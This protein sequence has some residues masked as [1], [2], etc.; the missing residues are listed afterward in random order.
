MIPTRL[1]I[2]NFLPYR[3]PDP[4]RFDGVHLACL[5]GPNGAGKSSLLDAITWALWGRAR[6]ARDDE[7]IHLGQEDMLV[8]LDFDQEGTHYRV[9]RRRTAGKRG[10]SQLDLF[11]LQDQPMLIS[12]PSIKQTQ[13][14]INEILR[15]DYDTFT[16]SAFL[17]QGKADS[18]TNL[19]PAKRKQ[20]LTDILG[21]DQ[22]AVYEEKVKERLKDI[23]N[24]L[25]F[26]EGRIME[27][28]RELSR[29]PQ[30]E[31]DLDAATVNHQ[32]AEAARQVAEDR[33]KE[34]EH[35]PGD[36][37][38][39]Q[40]RRVAEAAR[41]QEHQR[42]VEE[43][44]ARMERL[45]TQIADYQQ[46]VDSREEIEAGYAALQSARAA[47]R[48]LSDKLM[49]LATL[50]DERARLQNQI[51]TAR[52]RLEGE[53]H[54]LAQRIRELDAILATDYAAEL[55]NIQTQV[56]ELQALDAEHD[57]LSEQISAWKVERERLRTQHDTLVP[58]G[59][60]LRERL[61]M[62]QA[63]D[64][65]LCPT[66]GQ[67][68]S[69]ELK[70]KVITDITA[71]M[72]DKREQVISARDT[73]KSLDDDIKASEKQIKKWVLELKRLNPLMTHLGTLQIQADAAAEAAAQITAY[74]QQLQQLEADLD[75]EN[76]AH[77]VREALAQLDE[78]QTAIGYDEAE[79]RENRE[80]ITAHEQYDKLNTRLSIALESLPAVEAS[81]ADSALRVE[82]L[83]QA[84]AQTDEGL[85]ALD[86]EIERLKV[87][88]AE[89]QQRDTDVRAARTTERNAYERLVNVQ[90]EL[91]ALQEQ[92]E[93]KTQLEIRR[94]AARVQEGLYNELKRAFGKNGV[95]AM[96]IET[97][98]PELEVTAN[99]L[100][101]KMTD[102]RMT[103]R[104]NTQREKVTGGVAETL[105]IDIADE[106]GTRSYELYSGGEA[107]RI[108][109]ALRVALSQMLARRA[110]A[111]LR[112]LFIDEG[113]GTQDDDGRSKLTEAIT[114]IQ[115]EFDM[116]LVI[117]HIDELRDS[118]PVHIV[119]D[120]TP[121]GS[122]VVMR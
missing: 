80:A 40:E 55:E 76:Y 58:E 37:R 105:D 66:C 65:A 93:R 8:Q 50:K 36:L 82:R 24:N 20:I 42:D 22:W 53:G 59:I 32:E 61:E 112:T 81:L 67:P 92:A 110:G 86:A 60:A 44:R 91:R 97:A 78:Q 29:Q 68:L 111:H 71:E 1:E 72:D 11:V 95:P 63:S 56:A 41:R 12:E 45:N 21:L 85:L 104:L 3:S 75:A 18:F 89:Y 14:K 98:I 84:I 47:D 39:A 46:V 79:F 38:N 119:V 107:F 121:N 7:L 57:Q 70:D 17:Q 51:D 9:L 23:S 114:A 94:D 43:T 4:I 90:Q 113:F 49:Q 115:D 5:T 96:V 16:H 69:V 27:I 77:D 83:E 122:R 120:K 99:A 108:N 31:K 6:T 34:V 2:K 30:L 25:S 48:D 15:L 13:E 87:L 118:F 88:V 74:R 52:T 101:S 33:L 10:K 35:A 26:I 62:L 64:S 109:F 116:V 19:Q 106:L 54:N 102:G 103:L 117:T 100:L 73:I 28:E